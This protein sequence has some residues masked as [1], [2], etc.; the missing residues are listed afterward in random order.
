[1][2]DRIQNKIERFLRTGEGEFNELALELFA[3]QFEHVG[4]YQTFCQAQRVMPGQVRT[5]REIPAL[6]IDAFKR[7][8]LSTGL[9]TQAAAVF[10]SSTTTTGQPSRHF[11]RELRFYEQS[12]RAQFSKWVISDNAKMPFLILT[13]SPAEAPRSSLAWMMDVVK[14][15]WGAP[16]SQYFV[17]HGRLDELW[18]VTMLSKV[19]SLGEPVVLL[20]TTLAF[21]TLLD[22]CSMS[23]RSFRLPAGSRLMDTGGMKGRNVQITRP[24]FV[25]RVEEMLG[26]APDQCINEYGMC[27]MSSQFY[28]RGAKS[29]LE[30]PA[31]TRTLII[32]P[33]TGEE[34]P[35]GQPGLL[36]H[37]DLANVDS[38]MAIQTDDQGQAESSGFEFLGRSATASLKGCSLE[39]ERT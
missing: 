12:V 30:G 37:F 1:M 22:W 14:R 8:D 21:L 4:P 20:G 19:Q 33:D 15:Q 34:V 11:L 2:I 16:G 18:L 24:A 36:R 31:W 35:T 7:A 10:H 13:P 29:H 25:R 23:N 27:E 9:P 6:P 38:V 17:R 28:G 5:W 26:I 32:N 39:M 3:Y